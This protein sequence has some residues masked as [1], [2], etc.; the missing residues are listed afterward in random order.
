MNMTFLA[1]LVSTTVLVL[2]SVTPVNPAPSKLAAFSLAVAAPSAHL[3]ST[4][5]HCHLPRALYLPCSP[6]APNSKQLDIINVT[7]AHR[8]AN[9]VSLVPGSIS[10]NKMLIAPAID[11]WIQATNGDG[12]V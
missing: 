1:P 6:C 10:A 12:A 9:P 2:S 11:N 3:R 4:H 8:L 7:Q 5:L